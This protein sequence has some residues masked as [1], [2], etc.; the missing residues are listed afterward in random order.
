MMHLYYGDGKGKTTAALGLALRWVGRG[1]S[2]LV[3]QFLKGADSGERLALEQLPNV[4]LLPVPETLP[5][6]WTMT[7]AER[8]RAGCQCRTLLEQVEQAR[9]PECLVVLDEVCAAVRT[10]LLPAEQVDNF[11]DQLPP[12]GEVVL[13]GRDPLPQWLQRADYVTE[14]KAVRHPYDRGI[15]ARPGVEY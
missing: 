15:P 2:V 4:T 1:G 3:A 5:F 11:L 6:C 10:G 14:M 7:E 8:Q 13:T 12:E 9:T